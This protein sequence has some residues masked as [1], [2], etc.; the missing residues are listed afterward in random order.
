MK[1]A[2][3]GASPKAERYS[4]KA[5][6]MLLK[7]NHE[8][9]PVNP[10]QSHIEGLDVVRDLESLPHGVHTITVYVSPEISSH[11]MDALIAARPARVI[12]NPGTE[13]PV[14]AKALAAT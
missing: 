11:M 5:I 3:L 4:N 13:N 1:V 14:L 7:H 12:F 8:V 6:R 2:V 10:A 9:I